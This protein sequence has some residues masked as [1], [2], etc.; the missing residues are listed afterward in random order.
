[1]SHGLW[2]STKD[3]LDAAIEFLKTEAPVNSRGVAYQLY[4]L[5][6]I[7]SM[8]KA[9][10]AK[11]SR[12]LTRAR[13]E[14]VIP[15]GW[16]T[17]EVREVE[18]V[19]TFT[20]PESFASVMKVYRRQKWDAQKTNLMVISEKG[21]IRGTIAPIL[22]KY[23]VPFLV[24]HGF[25]SAT[26]INDIVMQYRASS[27]P[28]LLLYVGDWDPS[29]L[30]M[31]ERDLPKRLFRYDKLA[32]KRDMTGTWEDEKVQRLADEM[33]KILDREVEDFERGFAAI[34]DDE[35]DREDMD[36][37]EQMHREEH[38]GVPRVQRIALVRKDIEDPNLA[39]N[40]ADEKQGDPRY[41]WYVKRTGQNRIWEID[42]LRPTVLRRRLT[43]AIRE[44]IDMEVWER[45]TR[46]ERAERASL[47]KVARTFRGLS[48]LDEVGKAS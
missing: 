5:H 21:T 47:V 28:L 12:I 36:D 11:V 23:E 2:Q 35:V 20:D 9:Q 17:D 10:T 37:L 43:L 46:A 27:K 4:G 3:I 40:S 6:L 31:S 18:K 42:A 34:D 24:M 29:G 30:Y 38:Q 33:R 15:F 41:Q 39:S 14:G 45:Y 1:M 8:A 16:I 22:D 7:P 32:T 13:E 25:G 44:H 19:P 48:A 26:V